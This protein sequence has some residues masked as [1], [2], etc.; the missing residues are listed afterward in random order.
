M[1]IARNIRLIRLSANMEQQEFADKMGASIDQVRNWEGKRSKPNDLYKQKIAD[2]AGITVGALV[3]SDLKAEDLFKQEDHINGFSNEISNIQVGANSSL[4]VL[5]ILSQNQKALIENESRLIGNQ[6]QLTSNNIT[7]TKAALATASSSPESS[8]NVDAK[9]SD[10]LEVIGL[11]GTE[12]G[13]W[14]T[15][16]EA[17]AELSTRFF[18]KRKNESEVGIQTG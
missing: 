11:I 5:L 14:H 4:Q 17:F 8:L 16:E 12:K 18:G 13:W 10:V 15:A 6:E 7:L 3:Y 1:N 2:F 9:I